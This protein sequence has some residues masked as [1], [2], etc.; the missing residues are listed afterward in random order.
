[1]ETVIEQACPMCFTDGSVTMMV[2]VHEIPYFGEHTELTLSCREC[3]W[4]KTD[5][6]AGED[7]TPTKW[8]TP[9]DIDTISARIVRS[10]SCTV[11]VEELDLEVEPGIAADGYVSNVEGV[12]NRFI[13]AI[14]MLQRQALE[15]EVHEDASKC[16]DY[17]ARL[18]SSMSDEN[19]KLTL[20]L[21]D[22]MGNSKI[23][24]QTARKS[25]L[26][27]ED[28]EK[29]STGPSIPILDASDLGF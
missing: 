26:A 14:R 2:N 15:D 8:E 22:P 7:N 5:F 3:G 20:V 16:E 18:L 17:I 25:T 6:L 9:I 4:R 28:A 19:S 27:E 24:H 10:S 13:S 21:L 12:L 23:L 1:M 11:R 29:L